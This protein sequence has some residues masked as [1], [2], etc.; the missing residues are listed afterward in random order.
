MTMA[1]PCVFS[2]EVRA[3]VTAHS[4]EAA[5]RFDAAEALIAS[6][7]KTHLVPWRVANAETARQ[8]NATVVEAIQANVS[9]VQV[10]TGRRVATLLND[11]V[12]LVNRRRLLASMLTLRAALELAASVVYFERRIVE[13]LTK[14]ISTQAELDA[15][16]EEVRRALQGGR[17]DW[18]RWWKGGADVAALVQEYRDAKKGAVPTAEI[19]QTN[20]V[21]MIDHLERAAT[22]LDP[23]AKGR[24]T[25][26]YGLLSD[27]CHPAAGGDMLFIDPGAPS[28]WVA[29][30]DHHHDDMITWAV[31]A[32][33]LPAIVDIGRVARASI[34]RLASVARTLKE[35]A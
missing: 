35:E 22:D 5:E 15:L 23:A 27:M 12:D 3:L 13:R 21:T 7:T 17:F 14:G 32:V 20:V 11:T 29:H 26:L 33:T 8:M 18:G 9:A 6:F 34:H 30:L 2:N 4:V 10:S 28:G 31:S 24:V 25:M 19:V 1:T 16:L